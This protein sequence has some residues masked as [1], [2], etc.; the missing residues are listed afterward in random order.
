[1]SLVK[2]II[3]SQST[4]FWKTVSSLFALGLRRQFTVV[5]QLDKKAKYY[6]TLFSRERHRKSDLQNQN[7]FLL[8]ENQALQSQLRDETTKLTLLQKK[9]SEIRADPTTLRQIFERLHLLYY[10]LDTLTQSLAGVCGTFMFSTNLTPDQTYKIILDYLFPCRA[11]DPRL[12]GNPL[13]LS[14]HFSQWIC[15]PFWHS[16]GICIRSQDAPRCQWCAPASRIRS[17]HESGSLSL[18]CWRRSSSVRQK[19]QSPG[20]RHWK[21]CRSTCRSSG[22]DESQSHPPKTVAIEINSKGNGW[23]L[24]GRTID[25]VYLRVR[26]T[27]AQR[28]DGRS[29][30]LRSKI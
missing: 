24:T 8:H 7:Y 19:L 26:A 2:V 23:N 3:E 20:R 11:L 27:G 9:V 6:F 29:V 21:R 25:W 5:D 12:D 10:Q 17:V 4:A 14:P 18:V 1:M 22:A 28:Q 13:P 16:V 30:R 15:R